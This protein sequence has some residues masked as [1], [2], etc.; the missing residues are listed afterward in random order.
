M[1]KAL[2]KY[3]L[4]IGIFPWL[5]WA[6]EVKSDAPEVYVVKEGDTLWAISSLYLSQPWLWPELWRNN[7]HIQNPHLIY[8]GDELRLTYDADGTPQL[9]VNRPAKK[10]LK[11]SPVAKREPKE[12]QAIPLIPWSMLSPM[13]EQGLVVEPTL[14]ETLP[15]LLG[16]Y[17]K[18]GSFVTGDLVIGQPPGDGH[19]RYIVLRHQDDLYDM[20]GNLLGFQVRYVADAEPLAIQ[21]QGQNI[22]RIKVSNFEAIQGDRLAPMDMLRSVDALELKPVEGQQGHI[23]GNLRQH[24]LMGKYDIVALDLGTSDAIQPGAVFGIYQPA[25]TIDSEKK[26][27]YVDN[28]SWFSE[29]FDD[30]S[31]FQAPP[32]KVGELVV[33]KTFDNASYGLILRASKMI[34][35][36][37]VVARP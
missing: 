19:N 8:P 30:E 15:K 24:R 20:Q 2:R 18:K 33:F 25:P 29:A 9:S 31:V 12:Q 11:L 27:Q 13:L 17:D 5:V 16:D 28:S 37:N 32:L 4:L 35:R 14:F 26:P 6:V 7:S 21:P 1:V 23:V 22:V 10:M 34:E 36:G 3:L